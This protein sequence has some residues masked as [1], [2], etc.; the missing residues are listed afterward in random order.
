MTDYKYKNLICIRR[1]QLY[2]LEKN[3][4]NKTKFPPNIAVIDG[5]IKFLNL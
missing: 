5:N 1:S 2:S 3:K 4:L